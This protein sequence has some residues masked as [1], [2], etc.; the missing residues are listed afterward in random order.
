MLRPSL[1]LAY[2]LTNASSALRAAGRPS[3]PFTH[4]AIDRAVLCI[5]TALHFKWRAGSSLVIRH[6]NLASECLHPA[7]TRLAAFTWN[8]SRDFAV[9]DEW[10]LRLD[11]IQLLSDGLD[12][13]NVQRSHINTLLTICLHFLLLALQMSLLLSLKSGLLCRINHLRGILSKHLLLLLQSECSR[14]DLVLQVALG[15]LAI[16]LHTRQFC[17]SAINVISDTGLHQHQLVCQRVAVWICS[18]GTTHFGLSL[19]SIGGCGGP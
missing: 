4:L 13:A 10:P 15:G 14:L 17:Q 11:L 7:T 1:D 3:T 12:L 19:V 5:A 8:P 6:N 9:L 2:S 16:L 18:D